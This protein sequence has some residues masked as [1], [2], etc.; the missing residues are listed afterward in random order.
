MARL[1]ADDRL[2]VNSRS[3]TCTEL[4]A[5]ERAA[6]NGEASLKNDCGGRTPNYDSVN[7][8]RSLLANGTTRGLDDGVHQDKESHSTVDF[9]FIAAPDPAPAP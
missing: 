8:Y 1:L 3:G 9:P 7:I 6:L 2:W 4:F 5:V